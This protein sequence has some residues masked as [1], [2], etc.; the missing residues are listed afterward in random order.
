M[1]WPL[2]IKTCNRHVANISGPQFPGLRQR[3]GLA[4]SRCQETAKEVVYGDL[5]PEGLGGGHAC[6]PAT[7]RQ[8]EQAASGPWGTF[9]ERKSPHGQK[10]HRRNY[11]AARFGMSHGVP[12]PDRGTSLRTQAEG[13]C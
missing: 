7:R 1:A 10:E 8:P 9:S 6:S 11:R 2:H 5:V 12:L 4:H 13:G 3:A